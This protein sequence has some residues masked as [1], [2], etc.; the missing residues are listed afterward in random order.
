[1]NLSATANQSFVF[2]KLQKKTRSDVKIH[3]ITDCR[4][5]TATKPNI[6]FRERVVNSKRKLFSLLV[7]RYIRGPPRQENR[8]NELLNLY[9]IE[10]QHIVC[11][12]VQCNSCFHSSPYRSLHY[13][14]WCLS[15]ISFTVTVTRFFHPIYGLYHV[16][17]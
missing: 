11:N 8:I 15:W 13:C 2:I 4:Y 1:M 17:R 16:S 3:F 6:M 14:K 12:T 7:C 5:L 9:F 10:L